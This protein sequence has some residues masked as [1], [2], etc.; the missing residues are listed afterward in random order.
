MRERATTLA[1]RQDAA[2]A[3]DEMRPRL[4]HYLK[5]MYGETVPVE[6][7]PSPKRTGLAVRALRAVS[8][9]KE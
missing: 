1:A 3:F 4:Q 6:S 2:A 9:V 8:L 5:A 7:L